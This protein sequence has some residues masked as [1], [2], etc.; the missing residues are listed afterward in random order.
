MNEYFEMNGYDLDKFIE[1]E[2][3]AQ[4][5]HNAWDYELDFEAELMLDA[6]FA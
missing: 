4:M 6:C 1:N 3:E 2:V 5:L